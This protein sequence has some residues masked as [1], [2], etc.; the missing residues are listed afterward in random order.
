MTIALDFLSSLERS[1]AALLGWGLVDGFFSEAELEQRAEGFLSERSTA[2][3]AFTS[4]WELIER[5]LEDGLLWR[6]P[7]SD[8]YRTRMAEAVRLFAKLRQI[9]PDPQNG[10]WRSAPSLVA[11]Y[12][13]IVRPRIYPRRDRHA[14]EVI[15]TIRAETELSPLGEAVIRRFVLAD[16]PDERRL[17]G[18]QVRAASRILRASDAE[19]VQGTIVCAGTGSG[20]TL[21][22]YMPAYASLA[23]RLTREHWT[24]CLA[25]YPR[26][27][28][29]KDQLRE[30]LVNAR[31]IAPA[32]TQAHRRPFVIAALYGDVPRRAADVLTN[33]AWTPTRMQ[34]STAYL[35]P[36]VRCPSCGGPMVWLEADLN[37]SLERL[38]C[39]RCSDSIDPDEI[40][41]TRERL[42]QHPADVLFT[43]TEMLNQRMSSGRYAPLFG[44]GVRQDRRPLFA[45]LDEV[46][47]YEGIHGAHVALLLRRW[48]R[49][50]D[51]KVHFVGLSATLA[52][53]P[54]FFSDLAGMRSGDVVEVSPQPSEVQ[55]QG[56]EYLLALRSDPSSGASLLSTTIQCSM[57][58]RRILAPQA[59]R[60]QGNRIFA[61]TDNLDVTNRLYHSLLDA[62]GWDARGNPLVSRPGGSLANLRAT[63]LPNARQRF[64]TGQNW[65]VVED[66]GHV[67][68]PGAR[69]RVGRTSSQDAGV[70]A[71]AG[72]V[73]ATSALEVGFDDP[74]VGAVLQH[75]APRSAAAFLQ[76]KGRAGRR[77]EM[78]P[79]TVLSLSDYGRDRV[80]YQAYDQIFSPTLP[81]R[82]LPLDNRAVLR[83]QATYALADW[84]TRR[85]PPSELRTADPWR[86][87]SQPPQTGHPGSE[88]I[89]ARHH[90]YAA[91]LRGLLEQKSLRDEFTVFLARSL[92]IDDETVGALLWEPPRAVLMQ[93]VPTLLRRLE[94]SWRQA[95]GGKEY[96]LPGAP[97]PEFVPRTLFSDLQLPEVT[98]RLPGFRTSASREET[99]S[100]A[101]ALREFAPGRV[102]RRFGVAHAE[103]RHWIAP[104]PNDDV[105]IDQICGRNAQQELGDFAYR[106]GDVVVSVRVIRPFELRV[107]APP[108]EIQQTSNAFLSWRTQI[109]TNG[110]GQ[111][112]DL[113]DASAWGAII[114]SLDFYT[115][116][117]GQPI[118]LRR[119]AADTV[120]S[121]GRGR[122]P[123]VER[124]VRFVRPGDDVALEAVALGLV[125]DVDA[126]CV[127]FRYPQ[128]WSIV[129][130]SPRASHGIRPARFQDFIRT[131]PQL[132]GVANQF[133]RDW[134]AQA[135]LSS[136]VSEAMRSDSSLE[137]A[138]AAVYAANASVR[139]ILQ[140][141]LRW[142]QGSS[143]DDDAPKRVQELSDILQQPATLDAL[144]SN[145]A[146]LWQPIDAT[147]EPWLRSRFKATLGAALIDAAATLCPRMDSE[148]LLLDLEPRVEFHPHDDSLDELWLTETT[149]GGAGFVEEFLV[150]Y[151]EDPRRFFRLMDAAI[152]ASDLETVGMDLERVLVLATSEQEPPHAIA[153]TF[154]AI[155][156][157]TSHQ[158][159]VV[160]VEALRRELARAGISPSP[161]LLVALNTRVLQPGTNPSTDAYIAR[162]SADWN[163]AESRLG[164]DIDARVFAAAKSGDDELEEALAVSPVGISDVARAAWRYGVL[165]GML[166]P[167]GAQVRAEAMRTSNPFAQIPA[168][169]RLLLSAALTR[170]SL[171]VHVSTATW[172]EELSQVLVQNGTA[173][174]VG[175]AETPH[176]LAD[177][178]ARLGCEPIDS[179]VLL[180]HARLIGI[181][182]EGNQLRAT[183]ELPEAYQ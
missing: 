35:C 124:S 9:F 134:L 95:T 147:W 170:P 18:F 62:E 16:T 29:L 33:R 105:D 57:L 48:R 143:D 82:H 51:A 141:I 26:N 152:A 32:L 23:N 130:S 36:Y 85:L 163:D 31:R 176:L 90:L 84:I 64:D 71:A 166:W 164:A 76:R 133:Q 149:I 122:A 96:F 3:T 121:I 131:A 153:R 72:I 155:R 157:S 73:V 99:M 165:Y 75:K 69:V 112:V 136:I 43:T 139:S 138:E 21:A 102:S 160:A 91:S 115:H 114:T 14:A 66:V 55:A 98:I 10:A 65:A 150:H 125:G 24:K 8:R 104:S 38:V 11:D 4:G 37:Q 45:L 46:H 97:M 120:A 167:R 135:Y 20:K 52:D 70:D 161:T 151:S 127:T 22:F 173:E 107:S 111:S 146:C 81:V 93:A 30:A 180:V 171:S 58:L 156:E 89:A 60:P 44:I 101:Q 2:E 77:R 179:T 41:L 154:A 17:A 87:L 177:A 67:L 54:R 128:L 53:A 86:D 74:E 168:A 148:A 56:A 183:L 117:F 113:P 110:K 100:L 144:H 172:F 116:Q 126:V 123:A 159:S 119:F 169:D 158:Q 142:A 12:R 42:L 174:L 28:L 25:I 39:T 78:R 88:E 137:S 109:V 80:A 92:Q 162:L 1:E 68:A 19:R 5:L 49:A 6:L 50:A 63:T 94:R 129:G 61:F 79:W 59:E 181:T 83:M 182:R 132:N 47:T 34:T 7:N 178:L 27:E 175:S 118:E 145:A 108:V 140:T 13:L 40:R 15:A 103:E 106:D